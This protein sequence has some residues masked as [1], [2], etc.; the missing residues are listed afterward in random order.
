MNKYINLENYLE[1]G[2][3]YTEIGKIY[4]V[5]HEA[6][7]QHCAKN[8]LKRV[9]FKYE[10]KVDSPLTVLRKSGKPWCSHCKIQDVPLMKS[11]KNKHGQYFICRNC[12][13]TRFREY[14]STETGKKAIY[15]AK[16]KYEQKLK[17]DKIK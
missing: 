12:N 11:T 5:T 1:E 9:P 2:K 16:N 7:R 13:N 14:Y 6:I 8:G 15:R 10:L 3:T 17:I 4:G